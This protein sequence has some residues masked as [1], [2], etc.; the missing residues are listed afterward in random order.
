[1]EYH[2][3]EKKKKI[4]KPSRGNEKIDHGKRKHGTGQVGPITRACRMKNPETKEEGHFSEEVVPFGEK[5][6]KIK[7]G[8]PST[9]AI[10]LGIKTMKKGGP[11]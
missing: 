7:G 9:R 11:A 6:G 1:M 10:E 2:G 3:E 4:Q 8:G 5:P